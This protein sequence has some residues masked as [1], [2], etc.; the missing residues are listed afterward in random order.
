MVF[1]VE[2]RTTKYLH[3]KRVC[4]P[5][6]GVVL[7]QTAR[8]TTKFFPRNSQNYDFHENI[9][10]RKIP[11]ISGTTTWFKFRVHLHTARFVGVSQSAYL[12]SLALVGLIVILGRL[13]LMAEL[14]L[15]DP[16]STLRPLLKEIV[17]GIE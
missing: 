4:A 8:A 5:K 1:V 17:A 14:D 13:Q 6:M 7:T 2:R 16:M 11:A 10:P 12:R 9:T 3:T 15:A